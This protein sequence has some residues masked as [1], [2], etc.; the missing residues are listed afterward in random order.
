M[1]GIESQYSTARIHECRRFKAG[2]SSPEA[3]TRSSEYHSGINI[4]AL[5]SPAAIISEYGIQALGLTQA[6]FQI[7]VLY[8]S[9]LTLGCAHKQQHALSKAPIRRSPVG[10]D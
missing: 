7:R 10:L 1:L 9:R 8:A 6:S 3:V 2:E 4:S 5:I